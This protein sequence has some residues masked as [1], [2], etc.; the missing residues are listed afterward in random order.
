MFDILYDGVRDRSHG[1]SL[2]SMGLRYEMMR[3]G[4]DETTISGVYIGGVFML[5]K[6]IRLIVYCME[7]RRFPLLHR[8]AEHSCM[9]SVKRNDH[10]STSW[11]G[12]A[13]VKILDDSNDE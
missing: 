12:G 9:T 4:M 13:R 1:V 2:Q 11:A 7:T 5:G 6:G 10:S 3:N 8:R